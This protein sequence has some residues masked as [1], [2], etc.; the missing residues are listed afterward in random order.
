MRYPPKEGKIRIATTGCLVEKKGIEYVIRAVAQ[1]IKAHPNIEY[2][3]IGD[4]ELKQDFQQLISELNLD[5]VVNLLGW[6]N[7]Q[8]IIEILQHT[9]L[10]IAPSVT[11]ADGNQNHQ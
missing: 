7:E 10:F 5:S 11:A 2:N 4:G 8:E 9:H 1:Q 6:R 3:I